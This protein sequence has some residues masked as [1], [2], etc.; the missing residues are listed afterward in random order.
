MPKLRTFIRGVIGNFVKANTLK[1]AEHQDETY[2]LREVYP[3]GGRCKLF[4]HCIILNSISFVSKFFFYI[5]PSSYSVSSFIV[6]SL[7]KSIAGV[8]DL[9]LVYAQK[10]NKK[11][12]RLSQMVPSGRLIIYFK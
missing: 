5:F 3:V 7:N 1:K 2:H 11:K 10:E 9:I 6:W 4:I 12:P 8:F